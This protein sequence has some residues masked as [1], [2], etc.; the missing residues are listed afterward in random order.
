MKQTE[1]R[2]QGRSQKNFEADVLQRQQENNKV[3]RLLSLFVDD[4]VTDSIPFGEVR[5]RVWKIMPRETLQ[6][7]V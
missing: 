3:G 6:S 7:S 1:E 5:Q 2:L 4:D